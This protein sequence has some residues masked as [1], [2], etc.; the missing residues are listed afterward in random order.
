MDAKHQLTGKG[1]R[2]A[3][4]AHFYGIYRGYMLH[5]KV[6]CD[7]KLHMIKYLYPADD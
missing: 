2:N 5:A 4:R 3:K 6:L 7:S 1:T